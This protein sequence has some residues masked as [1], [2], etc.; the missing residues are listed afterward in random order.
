[1]AGDGLSSIIND[2]TGTRVK[3]RNAKR[4]SV[5]LAGDRKAGEVS[6]TVSQRRVRTNRMNAL[7]VLG[8]V[9]L[10]SLL[11]LF[12]CLVSVYVIRT[13]VLC[14]VVR[15]VCCHGVLSLTVRHSVTHFKHIRLHS[16]ISS[17]IHSF[18]PSSLHSFTQRSELFHSVLDQVH[19]RDEG[20]ARMHTVLASNRGT[21]K[22]GTG[23]GG[24]K[25]RSRRRAR[26]GSVFGGARRR[27]RRVGEGEGGQGDQVDT[28]DEEEEERKRKEHIRQRYIQV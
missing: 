25:G 2:A 4:K 11:L 9:Y 18:T 22:G 12:V 3:Q 6:L 17:F 5:L 8:G 1:M 27:R 26:V 23:K 7:H 15:D 14:G 10:S 13:C 16:F 24:S 21:G 19:T 20:K 28:E